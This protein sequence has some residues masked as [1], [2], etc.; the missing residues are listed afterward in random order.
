MASIPGRT[1]SKALEKHDKLKG[2]FKFR[3]SRFTARA[4]TLKDHNGYQDWHVKLDEEVAKFIEKTKDL[5]PKKFE[6]WLG[7]RYRQPDLAKRFP[8]GLGANK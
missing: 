8:G 1:P 4:A 5:D 3:D 2:V 7:K 6:S